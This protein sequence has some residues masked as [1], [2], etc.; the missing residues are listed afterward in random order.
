MH[1]LS[2]RPDPGRETGEEPR[3]VRFGSE[4]FTDVLDAIGSDTARGILLSVSQQPLTASE[5][6]DRVDTSVQNA[7]YHL[8]RLTDAGLVRVC[9]TVYSEKGCEMNLYYAVDTTLELRT[10]TTEEADR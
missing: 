7:S 1:T 2:T 3:V 5:I 6:A 4:A 8:D 10:P 9:D